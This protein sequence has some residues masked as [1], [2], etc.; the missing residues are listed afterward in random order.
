MVL[1]PESPSLIINLFN[2]A[3]LEALRGEPA[4]ALQFLGRAVELGY[5]GT[6]L[7]T[8]PDLDSLRG[9]PAFESLVTGV[10]SRRS[11]P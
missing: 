1:G 4:E 3:C 9:D 11:E 5:A 6:G 7:F 8:D 10:R 2:L